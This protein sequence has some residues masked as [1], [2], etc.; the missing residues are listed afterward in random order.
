MV[1]ERVLIRWNFC[2]TPAGCRFIRKNGEENKIISFRE[3]KVSTIEKKIKK[4]QVE[5]FLHE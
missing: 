5:K 3:K 1:I 2:L 4:K